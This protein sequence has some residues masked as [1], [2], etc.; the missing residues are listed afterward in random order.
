MIRRNH[1]TS[2]FLYTDAHKILT[3]YRQWTGRLLHTTPYSHNP[4]ISTC[5]LLSPQLWAFWWALLHFP[6]AQKKSQY[7]EA[8]WKTFHRSI[9]AQPGALISFLLRP[10]GT[11]L[12]R[13][14]LPTWGERH[15]PLATGKS[16]IKGK[17]W[18]TSLLVWAISNL[19]AP[20]LWLG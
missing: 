7:W 16:A 4:S 15:S 1:A 13:F 17:T 9:T 18:I 6:A 11:G 14:A 2:P 19:R 5:L 10:L 3:L 8:A 20:D 12:A